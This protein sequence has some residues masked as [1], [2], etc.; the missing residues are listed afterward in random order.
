MCEPF[1]KQL[2]YRPLGAVLLGIGH[3]AAERGRAWERCPDEDQARYINARKVLSVSFELLSI[4]K[5]ASVAMAGPT[6]SWLGVPTFKAYVPTQRPY[7][8]SPR[9]YVPSHQQ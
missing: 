9:P 2:S 4:F 3:P 1:F 7:V 6:S 5:N 8:P